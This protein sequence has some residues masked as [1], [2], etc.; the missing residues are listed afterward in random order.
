MTAAPLTLGTA[1][2]IDHGKTA[3]VRRLT[4]VDTD[5]LPEERARGISIALGYA[6]LALPSGRR[7]SVVDVPGHERFVR[8]MVS[9][10]TGIDLFLMVIAADDGVMP[11]TREHA[12]VLR[13]LAVTDGVAAITKADVADPDRAMAEVAEL[14]PGITAVACSARTG[15]GLDAL[16]AALDAVAA[17]LPGRAGAGGPPVL[18]VD[19]VFS[20]R[21][22]GTVVTGTLWSGAVARGDTLVVR[23]GDRRARVRA[24]H[25]H[26]EPVEGAAAGQRVALNLTGIAASEVARGDVVTDRDAGPAPTHRVDAALSLVRTPPARVHV[27]HGARDAPARLVPLGGD[28]WQ[29]RLERPLLPA[30]G[31]RIVVRSVAPADT[32]GGGVIVDAAP[33][34]HGAS[35]KVRARLEELRADGASATA[36]DAS[37]VAGDSYAPARESSATAG[38]AAPTAR[39]GSAAP[40]GPPPLSPAARAL[41]QRLLAAGHEPPGAAELGDCADELDALRDAGRAVRVGRA[42]YAHPDALADVAGR[43]AEIISAEGA[44]TIGR[45]RDELQTSR[46]Y[47]QAL[48]EHLDASRTT[49]R[50]PD[51]RRVLRA[52][53][54]PGR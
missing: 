29:A 15:T 40:A 23:P 51:D 33:A 2:H 21:G 22:A 46:K 49:L 11:Q 3:L 20:V 35:A 39:D 10:A 36:G 43:V 24:V 41:E 27:H 30:P 5:R 26:D 1:G 45:L 16:L 42:M 18:H 6:R 9:G 52:R 32:L 53:G 25:V 28:L 19:R 44:I 13:A 4:G 17:A 37:A 34:R 38:D 47:A 7:L 14:L 8:T 50:L 31:D 48:L 54:R 12:E